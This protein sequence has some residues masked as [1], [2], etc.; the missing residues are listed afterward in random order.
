MEHPIREESGVRAPSDPEPERASWQPRLPKPVLYVNGSREAAEA[1]ALLER[2]GIDFEIR[3][4]HDPLIALHWKHQT[5]TDIFGI[6]D[7]IMFAGR[8]LP[9]LR[10]GGRGDRAIPG[11]R[12]P[13]RSR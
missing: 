8:L 13:L 5:Y 3:E 11:T 9:E 7:F 2:Y 12:V 1:K 4:A 6:A 10:R